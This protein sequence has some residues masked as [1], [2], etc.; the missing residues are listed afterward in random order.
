MS[1]QQGSLETQ[2]VKHHML[3]SH[4]MYLQE[5]LNR[6]SG[7]FRIGRHLDTCSILKREL[8]R[9]ED[10]PCKHRPVTDSVN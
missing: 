9:T 3:T 8:I 5:T 2:A 6:I 10:H 1:C 7:K 4:L